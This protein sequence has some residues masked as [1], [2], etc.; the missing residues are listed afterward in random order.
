MAVGIVMKV[1]ILFSYTVIKQN[2]TNAALIILHVSIGKA[3]FSDS[4]HL[5]APL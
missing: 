2:K 4:S 3:S 5:I 1:F